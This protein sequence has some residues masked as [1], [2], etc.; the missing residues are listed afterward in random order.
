VNTTKR[1]EMREPRGPGSAR[2]WGIRAAIAIGLGFAVGIGG[3][4]AGV[5]RLEPG[6]PGQPDSLQ[7]MLDSLQ[8]RDDAD[9]PMA[10]RRAA[11]SLDAAQRAQRIADSVALANDPDAPVVPDVIRMEEGA[12]RQTIE[13]AGLLVG[14]VV[15]RAD[16]ATAGTVLATMPATGRKVRAGTAIDLVLS[17]GRAGTADTA[18]VAPPTHSLPFE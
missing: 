13:D 3:G 14:S 18:Q 1:R 7:L 12:A 4:I 11:D 9:A 10:K 16:S 2:T 8:R 6:R 17:D 15:F 5:N